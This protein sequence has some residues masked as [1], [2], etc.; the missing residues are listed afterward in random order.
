[1]TTTIDFSPFVPMT[2]LYSAIAVALIVTG[3]A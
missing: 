1:M 3:Y 2:L